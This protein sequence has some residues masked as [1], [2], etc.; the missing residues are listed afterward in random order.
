MGPLKSKSD[1]M[2][3]RKEFLIAN[4][5]IGRR[6]KKIVFTTYNK[7]EIGL[8]APSNRLRSISNMIEKEWL[9]IEKGIT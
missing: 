5:L 9:K 4:T 2:F 7:C 3:L 1:C 6:N 8:N